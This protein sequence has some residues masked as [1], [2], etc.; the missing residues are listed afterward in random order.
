MAVE[1]GVDLP[2]VG[3]ADLGERRS[4]RRGAEAHE[5]EAVFSRPE[6]DDRVPIGLTCG[7]PALV[8]AAV[9]GKHVWPALAV[10]RVIPEPANQ[11]IVPTAADYRAVRGPD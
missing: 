9:A 8:V 11:Y 4:S 5:A 7:K 3:G 6:V 2:L 10:E 1:P